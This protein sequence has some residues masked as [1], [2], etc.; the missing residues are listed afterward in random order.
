[1]SR[2]SFIKEAYILCGGQSRRMGEDKALVSLHG[3]PM[4]QYVIDV[5][6]KIAKTV[7]LIGNNADYQDFGLPV[8]PDLLLDQGPMG[9]IYTALKYAQSDRILILSCDIPL[10]S[11]NSNSI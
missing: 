3:K 2:A 11:A 4:I 8:I 1:M 6:E 7:C 10:I 5:A 9:G